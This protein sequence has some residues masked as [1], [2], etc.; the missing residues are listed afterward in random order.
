[1]GHY[2]C[3]ESPN[4]DYLSCGGYISMLLIQKKITADLY[5]NLSL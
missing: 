3:F 1:M 2:S 5:D 4:R